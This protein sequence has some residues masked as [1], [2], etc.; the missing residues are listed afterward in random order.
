[1][2]AEHESW[3]RSAAAMATALRTRPGEV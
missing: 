3:K 1:L 2:R